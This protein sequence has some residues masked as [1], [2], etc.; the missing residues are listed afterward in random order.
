MNKTYYLTL[1]SLFYRPFQYC[2]RWLPGGAETQAAARL[3]HRE[4]DLPGAG[5]RQLRHLRPRL[6]LR[7]RGRKDKSES[8]K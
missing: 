7:R 4:P 5:G 1:M 3:R 2:S 6:L 8:F